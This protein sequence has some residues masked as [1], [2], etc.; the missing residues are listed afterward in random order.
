MSKTAVPAASRPA[1]TEFG[2]VARGGLLNVGGAIVAA[3]VNVLIVLVVAR[4]FTPAVAGIFFSVTSVFLIIETVAKLG[5][6]T[7]LVYFLS[8]HRALNRPEQSPAVL[9][10]ALVPVLSCALVGSVTLLILAPW[11]AGFVVRGD[12]GDFVTLL[13]IAAIFIPVA[14]LSD[15]CLAAT[16]GFGQMAATVS[17]DRILRP[18]LQLLLI[19]V[20]AVL[21]SAPLLSAAWAGPYLPAAALAVFALFRIFRRLARD[22]SPAVTDWVGFWRFT[23]PRAVASVAQLAL[24]RLD[25]I[26]V[27]ALRGPAEAAIYTAATRFL[28]LGQLGSQ[29]I[30]LAVQPQLGVRLAQEDRAGAS[31]LYQTGTAWLILMTWPLYLLAVLFAPYLLALFG[32]SYAEGAIV[33]VI[34]CLTM[35]LA[36]GCG[37]VDMVLSM[38]GRTSWNLAN[39]SLALGVNVALNLWLIPPLGITGAAIAWSVAILVNNLLPLAQVG[40]ILGLHPFGSA[41]RTAALLSVLGFG[42]LPGLALLLGA[43]APGGVFVAALAGATLFVWGCWRQRTLLALD[44]LRA[45][46]SQRTLKRTT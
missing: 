35:L 6:S 20:V 34:L 19:F 38:A 13:Q 37:M 12:P 4:S 30:A 9:R 1:P 14:A 42:L 45:L 23:T 40:L 39:S 10:V 29:A 2:S 36:T 25:I 5:T 21:G 27:A 8:R 26:L 41:T 31:R 33:V 43:P 44:S 7:G 24:Q 32:E 3:V 11:M 28:V 17:V 16:R 46:R 22:P 18:T 15:S